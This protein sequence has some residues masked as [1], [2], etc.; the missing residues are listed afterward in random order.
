MTN[1]L[2][3]LFFLGMKRE[4]RIPWVPP[5]GI[6][7]NLGAG[8]SPI[9]GAI[10]LDWPEWDAEDYCIDWEDETIACVHAYH[11]LEHLHDPI[12]MINEIERVLMP[13]GVLNICVPHY[14][15]TMA[16]QDLD[17]KKFFT[18]ETF[19][20]SQDNS[21]YEKGKGLQNLRIHINV[22]MAVVERN[23]AII[24]Q[25]VKKEKQS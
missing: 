17:H 23:M 13:G 2:H 8:N 6:H 1:D 22:M 11:F 12:R 25:L 4:I 9:N 7:L 20:Q 5:P 16:Y 3:D 21:F 15:G 19:K 24:A 10:S 18:L 14:M